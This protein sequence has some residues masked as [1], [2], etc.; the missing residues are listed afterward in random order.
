MIGEA[1][2]FTGSGKLNGRTVSFTSAAIGFIFS[3]ALM[4]DCACRALEALARK[5]STKDFHVLARGFLLDAALFLQLGLLGALALELVVAAA[6]E[7]Q[8]LLVEM[9][10][11]VDGAVEQVAVVR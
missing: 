9:D 6:P 2:V 11:R 8:L 4:R 1:T 5:R 7:G 10:D 3:S